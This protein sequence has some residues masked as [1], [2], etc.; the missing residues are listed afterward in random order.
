MKSEK[1]KITIET[2]PVETYL[3][4]DVKHTFVFD[5]KYFSNCETIE[6]IRDFFYENLRE[7]YVVNYIHIYTLDENNKQIEYLGE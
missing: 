2:Q 6:E 1:V 5:N 4:E 3:I 7:D